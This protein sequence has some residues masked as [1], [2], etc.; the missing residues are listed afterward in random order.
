MLCLVFNIWLLTKKSE[1]TNKARNSQWRNNENH[2]YI[3]KVFLFLN[4][5]HNSHIQIAASS[6]KAAT[7]KNIFSYFPIFQIYKPF[8][9]ICPL[10]T[11]YVFDFLFLRGIDRV[12]NRAV[13]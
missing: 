3:P 6:E 13:P 7:L 2:W 4:H 11:M 8:L 5:R 10:S 1:Y 9:C 12:V